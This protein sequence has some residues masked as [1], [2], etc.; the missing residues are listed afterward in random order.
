ML[1]E[2]ELPLF[3][4]YSVVEVIVRVYVLLVPPDTQFFPEATVIVVAVVRR[5]TK[6]GESFTDAP[7]DLFWRNHSFSGAMWQTL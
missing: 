2:A 3:A 4:D 6:C 5:K 1:V 7:P